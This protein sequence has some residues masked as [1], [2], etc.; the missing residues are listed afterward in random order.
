MRD[1]LGDKVEERGE[2]G[3]LIL[4]PRVVGG[5]GGGG[6][7]GGEGVEGGGGVGGDGKGGGEG[8][9]GVGGRGQNLWG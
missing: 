3:L 6:V 2:E 5:I 4:L 1:N 7:G 9:C 8:Y